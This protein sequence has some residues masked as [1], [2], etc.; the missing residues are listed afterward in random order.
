MLYNIIEI[1]M[2]G[3]SNSNEKFELI[4][5]DVEKEKIYK[6]ALTE[7]KKTI[8]EKDYL[9]F[10]NKWK[11]LQNRIAYKPMKSPLVEFLKENNIENKDLKIDIDKIKEIRDKITHG[12]VKTLKLNI[13]EEANYDLYRI[14]IK[15]ILNQLGLKKF[16]ETK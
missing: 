14:S 1:L 9:D 16:W 3:K 13:V 11:T 8:S 15:L 6:I 2:A 12:S 5:D 4:V 10:E 7:L